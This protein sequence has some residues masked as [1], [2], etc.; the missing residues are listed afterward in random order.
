VAPILGIL[1]RAEYVH[2]PWLQAETKVAII[3]TLSLAEDL[4]NLSL[5]DGQKK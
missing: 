1:V 4:E 3:A 2:C 5:Q